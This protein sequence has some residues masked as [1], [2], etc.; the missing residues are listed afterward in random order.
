MHT[1]TFRKFVKGKDA[2][3]NWPVTIKGEYLSRNFT[4][5][6]CRVLWVFFFQTSWTEYSEPEWPRPGRSTGR[7]SYAFGINNRKPEKFPGDNGLR[8]WLNIGGSR[9]DEL[10]MAARCC[11][12]AVLLFIDSEVITGIVDLVIGFRKNVVSRSLVCI[13]MFVDWIV[14]KFV[15]HTYLLYWIN[16]YLS[17]DYKKYI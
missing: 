12:A 6:V 11:G 4:T 5:C 3:R 9:P 13:S 15:V 7:F 10:L 17:V 14:H 1:W 2:A 16:K 8:R